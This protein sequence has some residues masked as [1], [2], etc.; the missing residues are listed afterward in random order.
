MAIEIERKFLLNGQNWRTG[1]RGVHYRQGYLSLDPARTVRVRIAGDEGFL[2]IKG[3]SQGASRVEFEYPIPLDQARQLLDDLC[4]QPRIEKLRYRIDYQGR[5]WEVDQFLGDNAGLVLAE[6][7]LEHA[8]QSIELPPWIGEEVTGDPRY[9]N[10]WLSQHPYSDW[11]G[12]E[13]SRA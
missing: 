12:V 5:T 8:D 9:Y 3:L 1:A 6:V 13:E 4:H 2:T 7:E 10:A 11:G